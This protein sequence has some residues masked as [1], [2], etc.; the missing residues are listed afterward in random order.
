MELK[1]RCPL[2]V[3]ENITVLAND[4]ELT[5][6]GIKNKVVTAATKVEKSQVM[7]EGGRAKIKVCQTGKAANSVLK[8]GGGHAT[9]KKRRKS[10]KRRKRNQEQI[11]STSSSKSNQKQKFLSPI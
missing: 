5:A 11:R 1:V 3:E 9:E 10:E 6:N 8:W 4:L 2:C 7:E